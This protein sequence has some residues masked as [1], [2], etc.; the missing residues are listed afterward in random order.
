MPTNSV[1]K[2]ALP[3]GR[4]TELTEVHPSLS[5]ADTGLLIYEG[6]RECARARS[7]LSSRFRG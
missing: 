5:S 6:C 3:V 7:P 4:V 1:E 2:D